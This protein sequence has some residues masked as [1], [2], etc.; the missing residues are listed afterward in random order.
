MVKY[1][2]W[3]EFLAS[4]EPILNSFPIE[5]YIEKGNLNFVVESEG[6]RYFCTGAECNVSDI[7]FNPKIELKHQCEFDSFYIF[8]CDNQSNE[9]CKW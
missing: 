3:E 2:T 1:T 5:F 6:K 7:Y 4:K 9:I 8:E